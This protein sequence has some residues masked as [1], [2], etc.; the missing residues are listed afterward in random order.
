MGSSMKSGALWS[1]AAIAL[2]CA[3]AVNGQEISG[4]ATTSATPM[5]SS[6]NVSQA[7]LGMGPKDAK[8]W[9]HSNG[10]YEQ[11]RYYNGDQI[12]EG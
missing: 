11:T 5:P 10:S 2:C 8:N 1:L 9:L 12:N 3:A 6:P 4:G 7:A